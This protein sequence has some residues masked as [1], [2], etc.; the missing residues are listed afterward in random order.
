[1]HLGQTLHE[2][3]SMD[4]DASI[5]RATFIQ[6][7]TEIREVFSFAN[8]VEILSAIK[9]YSCSWY[10]SVLWNLRGEKA[11]QVFNTWNTCVKLAWN[12]PRQAHTYFVDHLLGCGFT[13][14]KSDILAQYVG[15]FKNL[16]ASPSMEV[17]VMANFSGRNVSTVT[18]SNLDYIKKET[19]LDPW[20]CS[21]KQVKSAM[22]ANLAPLPTQSSW[23]LPFLGKLLASRGEHFYQCKDT[24]WIS[25]QIDSLC[26]N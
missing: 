26:I 5:K 9:V 12:G 25:D 21:S 6:E 2:S 10:G 11:T 4:Q 24:N 14:V 16:R 3:G 13:S 1:M 23:R 15:F 18:G 8:P 19:Q 22:N 7:S 17:R 20:V